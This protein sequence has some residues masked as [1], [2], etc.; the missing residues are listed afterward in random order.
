LAWSQFLEFFS[1][2]KAILPFLRKEHHNQRVRMKYCKI[3]EMT[4]PDIS[5]TKLM[6]LANP[7]GSNPSPQGS[8]STPFSPHP[9]K[10]VFC[11]F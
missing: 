5:T 2:N 10:T 6:P 4:T 3:S 1:L 9:G 7:E 8:M 11:S